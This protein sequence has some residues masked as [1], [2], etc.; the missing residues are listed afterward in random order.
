MLAKDDGTAKGKQATA[1]QGCAL[2]DIFLAA[3]TIAGQAK[4]SKLTS[5]CPYIPRCCISTYS[6]SHSSQK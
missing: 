5:T 6:M 1:L 2:G 3:L 4:L